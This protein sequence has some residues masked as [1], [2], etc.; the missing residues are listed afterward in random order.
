MKILG[1]IP[2]RYASTRFPGKPL[3]MIGDKSMIERVYRQSAQADGLEKVLVATDDERIF[4]H[5]RG[6]G[7]N[8]EMT[9]ADHPTGT[10][11]ILE[12]R[13]KYPEYDAFVNIQGDEPFISPEQINKVCR[14]LSGGPEVKIGTLVRKFDDLS[15]LYDPNAIK[16]ALAGDGKALYFSR[17][18]LPFFRGSMDWSGE[19]TPE[20]EAFHAQSGFWQHI[21]IYGY[22]TQA[23]GLIAKLEMGILEK[24]ES[25]E[26]L[27]WME[28]GIPIFTEKT[29][30]STQGVDTPEDLV[31]I[32]EMYGL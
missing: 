14:L 31:R 10:D 19:V 26:Q 17:S 20:M 22:T 3:A 18:P 27:R 28:N 11:R 29:E 8:V 30:E 15:R 1:V 9:S 4:A 32:R 2:A 23:L 12:I 5:I 13:S 21:G 25:L 6:F 16:V 7:G 24:A